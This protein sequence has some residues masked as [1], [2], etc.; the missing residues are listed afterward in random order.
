MY[1]LPDDRISLTIGGT[2]LTKQ[3]YLVS[4]ASNLAAGVIYGT[5]NRPAEWYARLAFKY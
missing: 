5:Y 1:S 3:R 4:G 2:N